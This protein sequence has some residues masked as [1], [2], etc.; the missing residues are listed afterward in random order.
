M[1]DEREFSRNY[2]FFLTVEGDGRKVA[3]PATVS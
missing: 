3:D 2:R 1:V